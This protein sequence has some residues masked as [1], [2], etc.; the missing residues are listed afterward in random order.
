[1]LF[2]ILL[3]AIITLTFVIYPN[4]KNM[5]EFWLVILFILS[6]FR[7]ECVGTDTISY[8]SPD[9]YTLYS[10]SPMIGKGFEIIYLSV[11]QVI[12]NNNLP[13]RLLLVFMSFITMFF[14]HKTLKRYEN[15]YFCGL[16]IYLFVF[17][18]SSLNV[19]RQLCACSIIMYG[20][21]FLF[22][23]D[24]KKYYFLLLVCVASLI[25]VSSLVYLLLYVTRFIPQNK[26]SKVVLIIIAVI[27]FCFNVVSPFN[28]SELLVK[29]SSGYVSYSSLYA[30]IAVT[31]QRSFMGII[32]D[33][34]KFVALLWIFID[35]AN[36]R[37][38]RTDIIFYGTIIAFIISNNAH[39]DISRIFLPILIYQVIYIC[40]LYKMRR[41]KC[42]NIS[43]I[44][45]LVV[46]LFFTLYGVS[47]G[48]GELVPYSM[49]FN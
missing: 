30:D 34:L 17:Y 31:G 40:E 16:V 5:G 43:F 14:L 13:A 6:A 22:E 26:I 4:G 44:Y 24:S 10:E 42:S 27:F 47:I 2:Y 36:P 46:N 49:S 1:M 39:S 32:T 37:L 38:S 11:V 35:G 18:L 15:A 9:K 7:A 19:A 48:S 8:L 3:F 28:V 25:H 21:T 12:S 41:I 45:Y 23:D 29:V 20:Y 33:L